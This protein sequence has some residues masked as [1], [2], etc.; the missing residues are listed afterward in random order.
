MER[1]GIGEQ[2]WADAPIVMKEPPARTRRRRAHAAADADG[3]S[4]PWGRPY[5]QGYERA[6]PLHHG[7]AIGPSLLGAAG[8][9]RASTVS[10][11][12]RNAAP[13][14]FRALW[15]PSAPSV[16]RA[17][18]DAPPAGSGD[19]AGTGDHPERRPSG[20]EKTCRLAG[21]SHLNTD[22][23]TDEPANHAVRVLM[24]RNRQL[25][26]HHAEAQ[27]KDRR[28]SQFGDS[29]RRGPLAA[30]DPYGDGGLVGGR[31]RRC[32]TTA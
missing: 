15:S 17:A 5:Q 32:R 27:R 2:D 20:G 1:P 3:Q 23:T 22:R 30:D 28:R 29:D 25:H 4:A 21:E 9:A 14:G 24:P 7:D 19:A 10:V 8:T 12:N 16:P 18:G 26:R 11:F 13:Q 6:E 31:G